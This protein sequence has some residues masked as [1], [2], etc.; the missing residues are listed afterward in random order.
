ML[1]IDD[2]YSDYSGLMRL[3]N[4]LKTRFHY[5][6]H[7]DPEVNY[8]GRSYLFDD[9]SDRELEL[10][11]RMTEVAGTLKRHGFQPHMIQMRIAQI[12]DA[13]RTRVHVDADGSLS[14]M[15]YLG[16]LARTL[17]PDREYPDLGTSI[18]RHKETGLEKPPSTEEE[19]QALQDHVGLNRLEA[20]S[21]IAR[22]GAESADLSK[23]IEIGNLP[24]K[25]NRLGVID[26]D[27]YHYGPLQK[28]GASLETGR[29]VQ[30]F[31]CHRL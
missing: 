10:L 14:A 29:L 27:C 21:L 31:F 24:F 9:D 8:A 28:C 3:L 25:V 4:E 12:G 19:W 13:E 30:I 6:Q 26:A 7:R 22:I 20:E 5:T 17:D 1:I 18:F 2:V 11:Q 23:W 15:V 16:T